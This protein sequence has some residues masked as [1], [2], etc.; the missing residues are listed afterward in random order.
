MSGS[1]SFAPGPAS[2]TAPEDL[3]EEQ[4]LESISYPL[5]QTQGRGGHG[6][7]LPVFMGPPGDRPYT[8]V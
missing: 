6:P 7:A 2:L 8:Q 4:V 1:Q 5:N 3:L